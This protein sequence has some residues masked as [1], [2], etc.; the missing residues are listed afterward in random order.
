RSGLSKGY[1]AGLALGVDRHANGENAGAKSSIT[2]LRTWFMANWD[3]ADALTVPLLNRY[4]AL[5]E[6]TENLQNPVPT[7][8]DLASP[9][10]TRGSLSSKDLQKLR[11]CRYLWIEAG[12]VTKN[13]GPL[14]PGN[15]LM[16]KRLSR[17]YFG[18]PADNLPRNSAIGS[19]D[20]S[21]G[22]HP[23]A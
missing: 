14:L 16:M 8:D 22:G 2:D 20:I 10:S 4:R 1:E 9:Y 11:A 13:R 19:V 5:Y 18:F 21:Y 7:E 17:V 15:Q 12:G 6:S 3:A 23:F